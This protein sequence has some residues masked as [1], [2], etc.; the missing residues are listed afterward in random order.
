MDADD[1]L[2]PI[3]ALQ[4]L[5]YCERQV[6]LIHVE[7]L[8]AENRLTAEGRLAHRKVDSD[9]GETRD[10]IRIARGLDLRSESLKLFGKADVVEFR[11]PD[12]LRD[13]MTAIRA[14]AIG[15]G[16]LAGWAVTPVE[17]KRG[18]PKN[19]PVW[20]DC[21]RV[22]LCA[23]AMALEEMLSVRVATGRLFYGKTR[24]REDVPIDA[25]LR[26]KTCDAARRLH[27]LVRSQE[28]PPPVN[29]RRCDRCSLRT[30]CMPETVAKK[31]SAAAWTTTVVDRLLRER[32]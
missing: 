17:H 20:G 23:Q 26:E 4:H 28:T 6:A 13:V 22:Q 3:S 29:D 30:L 1:D 24:R 7:R 9:R 21:D 5:I 18:R 10:G 25:A 27:A 12:G 11:P 31:R 16:G 15:R 8:W 2:L 32:P 19:H 14:S